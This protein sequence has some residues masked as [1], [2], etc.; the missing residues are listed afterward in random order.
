M[1]SVFY[2]RSFRTVTK[3]AERRLE[4]AVLQRYCKY[5]FFKALFFPIIGKKNNQSSV[6]DA[7][8]EIPTLGSTDNT[9]NSVNLVSRHYPFTLGL[10]S[11]G[12]HRGPMI[13]S[14]CQNTSMTP[15]ETYGS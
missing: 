2:I 5:S 1:T 12:L 8:R 13:D 9:G 7:D 6:S 11:L 3:N 14:I 4:L 10:E 15:S